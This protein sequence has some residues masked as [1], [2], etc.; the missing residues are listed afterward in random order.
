[1]G[2]TWGAAGGFFGSS[3][4]TPVYQ[5]STRAL[6]MR[7]PLE[8]SSDM[9][10]YSDL[11]L[12]QTYIQLLTT[13]PVLDAA[14]ARLGYPVQKGQIKITQ[15]GDTHVLVVTIED[16]SPQR[17]TEIANVL[18]EVMIEQNELLQK[19][20]FATTE[21]SIQAQITQ[22][23]GQINSLQLEVD[24][25]STQS[26]QDQLAQVE[27][28]IRPLEAQVS[29]LQQEIAALEA[30]ASSE[31]AKRVPNAALVQESKTQSAEKRARIEQIQPL[32][33]LY[34]EI[35]SNLV[36]LGK[37]VE[38]GS[39]G[40]SR[41]TRLQAT[42]DLYQ[43]LYINLV[44]SLETVRLARLQTTPNIVQI[45][46]AAVPKSPI[47]PRPLQNTALA[48]AV[49]LMLAAGIAFLLEYLDDTL[50]TPEDVQRVL[51]LPVL[52]FVAQMPSA[53]NARKGVE[54][55][56]VTREP[57]SPVTEAFRTLRTNLEFAAVER[58][59]CTL[60][61]TSPGPS[62]GKT[63]VSANLAAIYSQAKKR[64]LLLDAD[65]RRPRIHRLLGMSNRNGLSNIF[66]GQDGSESLGRSKPEL[67]NLL[68]VTSGALPPNPAELLGSARMDQ[69]LN[70]FHKHVDVVIIDTPPS[71]VADAQILAGKV[72]AVLLVIQP[73]KT[74]AETAR[75]CLETLNRSG[76]RIV[77]VVMNR[78]PR[79]RGYYYGGYRYYA[80][81]KEN[82]RYYTPDPAEQP[83]E[84]PARRPAGWPM[85]K[86]V[87]EPVPAATA[88]SA[89][90][91]VRGPLHRL[92]Q[93]QSESPAAVKPDEDTKPSAQRK[94]PDPEE[95]YPDESYLS[96][97]AVHKL[98]D[99]LNVAPNAAPLQSD[100]KKNSASPFGWA[101]P[102]D[103]PGD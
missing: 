72:D 102:A 6:V 92:M 76:A 7:P 61:V 34:Q 99:E 97:P 98:F 42:L 4:Q 13:Q 43:S 64:V 77:G 63:T 5:A 45:E 67:P 69:I 80:S 50:K 55:I 88:A 60:L 89:Q 29:L 58:P 57:R 79:N 103:N 100:Q 71:L 10:Y 1:V 93:A 17:A 25:L 21:E 78:I 48:A 81:H 84:E 73:G 20:R 68:V 3:Y 51:G 24:S 53:K 47:R 32:L 70:K 12:V 85:H 30:A 74:H 44:S 27:S 83:L 101:F 87:Q 15:T 28:Q 59:I 16:G 39:N 96:A 62:E 18:I 90:E 66:L 94:A 82:K 8:Q 86:P 91:P 11:Q 95:T 22:V 26:F 65:M 2:L 38:S 46:P 31:Q 52:G 49:G 33:T 40:D 35:Y 19:S 14:S 36:V 54:E 9:T 37:P 41:M 56:F 23:E 75:A